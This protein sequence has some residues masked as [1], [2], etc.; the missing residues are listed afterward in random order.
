MQPFTKA[1]KELTKESI[2]FQEL[3]IVL[4]ILSTRLQFESSLK[5]DH[6]TKPY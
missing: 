3:N 2:F 1:V 6:W 4:V 5:Y